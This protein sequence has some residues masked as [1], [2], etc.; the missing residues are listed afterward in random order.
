MAGKVYKL[1]DKSTGDSIFPVTVTDAVHNSSGKT[2]T[3]ILAGLSGNESNSQYQVAADGFFICDSDGNIAAQLTSAGFDCIDFVAAD[4][5]G[6]QEVVAQLSASVALNSQS[7]TDLQDNATNQCLSYSEKEIGTIELLGSER[8]L[9]GRTFI[10]NDLPY[11]AGES[12]EYAISDEPLGFNL[13]LSLD[14]VSISTDTPKQ[15]GRFFHSC[16]NI[17]SIYVNESMQTI[18][19]ISCITTTEEFINA[20]VTLNYVKFFGDVVDCEIN[21]PDGTDLSNVKVK[22]PL[23]KYDKDFVF[24][25]ITDD[26]AASHFNN[27]RYCSKKFI[28]A[29]SGSS[30]LYW[31]LGQPKTNGANSSRELHYTDGAGVKHRFTFSQAAWPASHYDDGRLKLDTDGWPQCPWTT[32]KELAYMFDFGNHTNLHD[33]EF[34]VDGVNTVDGSNPNSISKG[35]AYTSNVCKEYTGEMPKVMVRPNGDDLYT[36]ASRLENN[37]QAIVLEGNGFGNDVYP[38][39]PKTN[40]IWSREGFNTTL[41]SNKNLLVRTFRTSNE[42]YPNSW[43]QAQIEQIKTNEATKKIWL[44]TATHESYGSQFELLDFLYDNYGAGGDDSMW[45]TTPDE[46]FEWEYIRN[47]SQIINTVDG[48]KLKV[49]IYVPFGENFYHHDLSILVSGVSSYAGITVV[50]D[51]AKIFGQSH[52]VKSGTLLL[53]LNFEEKVIERVEKYVAL[54]KKNKDAETLEDVKYLIQL[55]KSSL[56]EKYNNQLPTT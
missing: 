13:Y 47:N 7:I 45:F 40:W 27:W 8:T 15:T 28:Y 33:V 51:D 6:L 24:S 46:F 54:Y 35:I 48:N 31:H 9:Y 30:Y 42:A 22:F 53:N 34:M 41:K 16:Y 3:S 44:G 55:L 20:A 1:K 43:F 2:L 5:T 29:D 25:F 14:K 32:F 26:S 39:I 37:I 11:I 36:Y 50:T 10:L 38:P 19:K 56:R 4:F 49:K 18:L 12:K 52:V 17:D 23:L 21:F